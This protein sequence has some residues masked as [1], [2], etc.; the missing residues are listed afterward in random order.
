MVD[1]GATH[2]YCKTNKVK[3]KKISLSLPIKS[4]TMHGKSHLTHYLRIK[5]FTHVLTFYEIDE[6]D[7]YDMILG[8][9]GLRQMKAKLNFF[10]LELI[11]YE[12]KYT[13]ISIKLGDSFK[14]NYSI[15]ESVKYDYCKRIEMLM[16]KNTGVPCLPY[17]TKIKATIR[18]VDEEPVWSRSYPYPMSANEFVNKEIERLLAEGIIR[19]SRSPYNAPVWVVPKNGLKEEGSN[20][21]RMVID[22]KKTNA[23]T[24]RDKYPMPNIN[25]ILSNLGKAK[26]FS[27]IDLESGFHQILMEEK[28]KEK[29]AFSVNGAKYEFN[30]MPF[31]LRNAPSIFQRA[32]DDVLREFVGKF[33]HVYMDDAIVFSETAEEHILHLEKVITTLTEAN[34]KISSEKSKFFQNEVEF[35]GHFVST[36]KITVD[37]KKIETIKNYE[38]PKTVKQLRS[39]LGLSGYYRKF[40]RSYAQIVKPLTVHLQGENAQVNSKQSK[41]VKIDLDELAKNA[42][43]EIKIKL[44]ECIV[45]F[46]PDYDKPFDLITDA[47]NVAIGAVLEQNKQPIIFISR[48]L[49]KAEQSLATNEKELLAIVWALQSLRNY[50]YGIADVTVYTDHQPLT[51]SVSDKNPNLKIKRWQ[52]FVEECGVK[53]KYKP[54]NQNIVADALSRQYC[55]MI[56]DD[57]AS[58][59][60]IHSQCSS[61]NV[62][63]S[64][65]PNT[66]NS[67]DR[68]S[69]V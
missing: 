5:L 56:G 18:T 38:I 32:I 14:V 50:L 59:C 30:R 58:D 34:M 65:V 33:V 51:F 47:S 15:H 17:N 37:P 21:N 2:N 45:L 42:F 36:G 9:D 68:K 41:N 7:D 6:L 27:V 25:V 29:T 54:G 4:K 49:S 23:K 31:G 57:S 64:S 24:I 60:S 3:G 43:E 39:F 10:T 66:I 55:N 12:L 52:A 61:P 63:I 13:E 11:Y 53:M 69:V 35:L 48:T 8:Y 67:L 1:S 40:I 19:P 20:E 44:Q 16:D 46:Q 62:N 22:Y 28:D 26:Y